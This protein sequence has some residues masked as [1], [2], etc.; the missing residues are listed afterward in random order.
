M[1]KSVMFLIIFIASFYSVYSIDYAT[2]D[3]GIRVILHD[4]GTWEFQELLSSD[5]KWEIYQKKDPIT[6]S[7]QSIFFLMA[8]KQV[9]PLSTS[10]SLVIR[11]HDQE[12]DSIY[13][14][15]NFE[16]ASFGTSTVPVIYRMDDSTPQELGWFT[17]TDFKGLFYPVD[18]M[19]FISNLI[20]TDTFLVRLTPKN[21]GVLTYVFKTSGLQ[22]LLTNSG[23]L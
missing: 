7:I 5:S 23:L 8:D 15:F 12:I 19:N 14:N 13:I 1:K 20:E 3:S 2:T 22:D 21:Q 17:S 4:N 11:Y 18:E 9:S 16:V 10:T 6:D